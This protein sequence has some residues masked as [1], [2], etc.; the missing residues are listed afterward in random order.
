[1]QFI[2]TKEDSLSYLECDGLNRV[3]F[4]KKSEYEDYTFKLVE[5][6]K[7]RTGIYCYLLCVELNRYVAKG[8]V[9]WLGSRFGEQK[10]MNIINL[11]KM[12]KRADAQLKKAINTK[13]S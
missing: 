2:K 13:E 7:E 9:Q 1:M 6:R 8:T 4:H 12:Y 11:D 3:E 10:G 5:V